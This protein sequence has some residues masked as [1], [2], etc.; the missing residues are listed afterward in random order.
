MTPASRLLGDRLFVG[1]VRVTRMCPWSKPNNV[2]C[3]KVP[4][5]A[6][7]LCPECVVLSFS[8][9]VAHFTQSMPIH[10]KEQRIGGRDSVDSIAVQ[11]I[12]DSLLD[13]EHAG[14]G[15]ALHDVSNFY[16]ILF[17]SWLM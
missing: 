13:V 4:G 6:F 14:F 5:G 1:M 9:N 7:A 2:C 10:R 15:G 3:L 11:V 12:G 16:C 8:I 17:A